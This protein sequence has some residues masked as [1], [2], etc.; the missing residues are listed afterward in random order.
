MWKPPYGYRFKE[1]EKG[2]LEIVEAEALIILRC[3]REYVAGV[4]PR[5]IAKRLRDEGVPSPS[6]RPWTHEA[7]LG[8]MS[9]ALGG[10]RSGIIGNRTYLGQLHWGVGRY[11]LDPATGKRVARPPTEEPLVIDVPAYRIVPDDLWQAAH[12]RADARAVQNNIVDLKGRRVRQPTS[13]NSRPLADLVYCGTCG[14]H[15][16]L[17]FGRGDGRYRCSSAHKGFGCSHTKSYDTKMVQSS[18]REYLR[19][20][21]KDK[22]LIEAQLETYTAR[23]NELAASMRK[24]LGKTQKRLADIEAELTRV[25]TGYV[26]GIL[27]EDDVKKIAGPLL[28]ERAH[29][30]EREASAKNDIKPV[31]LHP[32]A[33]A[34][35]QNFIEQLPVDLDDMSVGIRMAFRNMVGRVVVKETA[36]R[37]AYDVEVELFSEAL[38]GGV[39]LS[40]PTG[41][42]E[43]LIAEQRLARSDNIGSGSP[44]PT[45]SYQRRLVSLGEWHEKVAA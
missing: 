30:R 19:D 39:N 43:K 44:A 7:I 41:G 5:E 20:K 33:F 2:K 35:C 8:G 24:K 27:A 34:F 22:K 14:S 9:K 28:D 36:P 38:T 25:Q 26:K 37:A 15:M 23:W 12:A 18:V 10:R 4:S 29:L 3:F 11:S 21:F 40:P 45:L 17:A 42:H 16:I 6:G 32:K 1:G 13:R 31:G